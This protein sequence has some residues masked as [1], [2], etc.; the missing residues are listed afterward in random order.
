MRNNFNRFMRSCIG[1]KLYAAIGFCI[2]LP[3]ISI[4][5]NITEEMKMIPK[6]SNKQ[7]KNIKENEEK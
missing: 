4:M 2:I 7:Q 1:L 3:I 6:N 5:A